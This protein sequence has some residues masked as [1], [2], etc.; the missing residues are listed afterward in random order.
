VS[1]RQLQFRVGLFVLTS[2]AI[3][4]VIVLQ[5]GELQ[6]YFEQRYAI[7]IELESAPGVQPGVPVEQNGQDIGKVREIQPGENGT[8]LVI[9][10]IKEDAVIRKDSRPQL[11]RSLLGDTSI[12]FPMGLDPEPMP[13][14]SKVKGLPAQD[15]LQIVERLDSKVQQ[16]LTAFEDTSREWQKVAVNVNGLIETKQGSL[17]DVVERAALSLEQFTRTMQ[18]AH[19]TLDNANRLLDDPQLQQSLKATMNALPQMV[20]E[21]RGTI[22]AARY[23][24]EK[25]GMTADTMN[26]TLA[27]MNRVTDPL[28]KA[29]P[30]IVTK[31]D[32]TLGQLD[33]LL[34]ELTTIAAVVNQGEGTIS[35]LARDP[36]LY[37]NLNRTA[38]SMPVVL[39]NLNRI[40]EDLRI[41]SDKIAR[42][43]EVLGV[44]GAIQ[45]SS[46]L[47]EIDAEGRP[48][49][50]AG[51]AQPQSSNR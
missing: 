11:K 42:H 50:R 33:T 32:S 41:F 48:I 30:S 3:G 44:R 6:S 17:D 2:L 35:K 45:G 20:E 23:S 22:A 5:F 37:D 13:P 47:K 38:A 21:T 26:V 40:A 43:P 36:Q 28:A 29:T 12:V 31:L 34:R 14:N 16:T 1:E 46:G 19:A 51:F 27:H 24:I 15:P 18:T 25:I 39:A 4:T 10:E 49:Q 8:V 9:V 7:A